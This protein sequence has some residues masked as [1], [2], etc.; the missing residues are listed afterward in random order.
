MDGFSIPKQRRSGRT[1]RTRPEMRLVGLERTVSVNLPIVK[2]QQTKRYDIV[3][4]RQTVR[5][6]P[7]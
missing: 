1:R 3:R 4:K 6:R 7:R 5:R 2:L